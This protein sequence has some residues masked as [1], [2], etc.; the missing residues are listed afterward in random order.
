MLNNIKV[1][2]PDDLSEVKMDKKIAR[3][4]S[5][6]NQ[7]LNAEKLARKEKVKVVE[8]ERT[9]KKNLPRTQVHTS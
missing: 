9:E 6:F 7:N 8:K 4:W 2:L 1:E 3:E 5:H